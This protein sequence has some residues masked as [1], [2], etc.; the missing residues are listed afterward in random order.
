MEDIS[1]RIRAV[2]DNKR[3][4]QVDLRNSGIGSQQT[5][6]NIFHMRNQPSM[7]FAIKFLELI[8]DVDA[9]WLLTGKGSMYGMDENNQLNE[10]KEPYGFCLNC[11]KKDSQIEELNRTKLQLIEKV[12]EQA[13]EIGKL[14]K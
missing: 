13:E 7:D 4:R 9:R 14:K 8:P 12:A 10:P 5:V 6:N 1:K 2:C 11:V 3:L